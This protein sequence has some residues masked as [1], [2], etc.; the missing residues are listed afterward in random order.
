MVDGNRHDLHEFHFRDPEKEIL[1]K[2]LTKFEKRNLVVK[3]AN[4]SYLMRFEV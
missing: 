3:K 1:K 2:N 4:F